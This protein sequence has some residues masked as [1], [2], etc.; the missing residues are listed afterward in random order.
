M[1]RIRIK[2][3]PMAAIMLLLLCAAC[4]AD[5]EDNEK[6]I[7]EEIQRAKEVEKNLS[8]QLN[9]AL[10][11]IRTLESELRATNK[12]VQLNADNHAKLLP[13][14]E[15]MKEK[16]DYAALERDS[17]D[18]KIRSAQISISKH[19]GKIK[20]LERGVLLN[21]SDIS[22]NEEK[23]EHTNDMLDGL[24]L[25]FDLN[26]TETKANTAYIAENTIK[27]VEVRA[28]LDSLSDGIFK[29]LDGAGIELG[30]VIAMN[31]WGVIYFD[32]QLAIPVEAP[33]NTLSYSEGMRL[34]YETPDCSGTAFVEFT[35]ATKNHAYLDQA[36]GKV[37][38]WD[39][40]GKV[41]KTL[42]SYRMTGGQFSCESID[43]QDDV[44][45]LA[46]IGAYES[47]TP[48][49]TIAPVE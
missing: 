2:C 28:R 43:W 42:Q 8:E 15:E 19:E 12:E 39:G 20:E 38:V 24:W 7:V 46:E 1:N 25:L 48:G 44:A 33:L 40:S 6:D 34:Y 23:I 41:T 4:T 21:M 22:M 36:T 3:Y 29:V 31:L 27:L 17:F 9:S 32:K 47:F 14:I 16:I 18:G 45:P 5:I 11:R 30:K 49:I 37:F 35:L 10:E 26:K 13:D